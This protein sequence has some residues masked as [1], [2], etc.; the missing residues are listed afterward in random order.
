MLGACR[1]A[2]EILVV[3]TTGLLVVVPRWPCS[4]V[5]VDDLARLRKTAY[6][7]R[8]RILPF[9]SETRSKCVVPWVFVRT[10]G[11]APYDQALPLLVLL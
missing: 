11:N 7:V 3:G 4:L 5:V 9:P 2:A 1:I 8:L 6:I 10:R